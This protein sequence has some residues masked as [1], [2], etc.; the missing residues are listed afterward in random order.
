MNVLTCMYLSHTGQN[1][2]DALQNKVD[3]LQESVI[4]KIDTFQNKTEASTAKH[5]HEVVELLQNISYSLD[6]KTLPHFQA[7]MLQNNGEP[8]TFMKVYRSYQNE[9]A[10]SR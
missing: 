10:N 5:H 4:N 8:G 6:S 2:V 7:P 3:M 9:H 1:K